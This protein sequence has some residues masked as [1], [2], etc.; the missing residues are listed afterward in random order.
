L[1]RIEEAVNDL[2]LMFL[3]TQ[4]MIASL[5]GRLQD[6]IGVTKDA[7][8]DN[9]EQ[10][11]QKA[12]DQISKA[13]TTGIVDSEEKVTTAI[14][15]NVKHDLQNQ[16]FV[17]GPHQFPYKVEREPQKYDLYRVW[18]VPED[19][20]RCLIVAMSHLSNGFLYSQFG[21]KWNYYEPTGLR[22]DPEARKTLPIEK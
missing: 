21:S 9:L 12:N 2:E 14:D 15:V 17:V 19:E 13:L 20:D 3:D 6:Y 22:W 8:T 4:E 7:V 10:A 5:E 16:M 11:L 18:D 1:R